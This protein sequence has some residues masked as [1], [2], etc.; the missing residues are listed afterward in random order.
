MGTGT[1]SGPAG[2]A[3]R[4]R[5]AAARDRYLILL[6]LPVVAYYVIFH[7]IP[8]YGVVIAFKDFSVHKGIL[9]SDWVGLVWFKQFFQSYYFFRLIRNTFLL[10]LY[11]L[12]WGFPIPILFA[13]LVDE[14]G[15]SPYKRVVQTMSYM[16]HF[17]SE[18]VMVGILMVLLSPSS[19]VVNKVIAGVGLRPVNFF[20]DKD[21]FRTLY[22]SSGIWQSF[23]WNSIIYL[24]AISSID[25]QMYEAAT[26]DGAGKLQKILY[27]TLPSIMPTVVILLILNIG[28]LMSVGYEKIILMYS[29]ATYETADVISTYVYRRGLQS[30]EY[31]F[32][33]AVGLFNSVVNLAFLFS[34]NALSRRITGTGLW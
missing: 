31:S 34:S 28:S 4:F 6:I 24:A 12:L 8:M 27:V 33:A 17:I 3:R 25:P 5:R 10:S 19:G 1:T 21:W 14:L 20:A 30:G 15:R 11:T 7:Y 32:A 18:V 29:P 16:P 13:L 22:V 26:L 2:L 9:G 23:G